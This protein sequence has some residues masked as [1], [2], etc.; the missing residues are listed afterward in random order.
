MN[1]SQHSRCPPF[2]SYKTVYIWC[3]Q[4]MII[5]WFELK[6]GI[7]CPNITKKCNRILA[8]SSMISKKSSAPLLNSF[9]CNT[10]V[11]LIYIN[12]LDIIVYRQVISEMK[13]KKWWGV[14]NVKLS[15]QCSSFIRLWRQCTAYTW[16]AWLG[17]I[18]ERLCSSFW[19]NVWDLVSFWLGPFQERSKNSNIRADKSHH[20]THVT[21]DVKYCAR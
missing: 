2:I 16:S 1:R 19:N 10:W 7:L 4:S 17:E 18:N 14:N 12:D 15:S 6:R 11:Y 20:V 21:L 5:H 13:M 3:Q 9:R 8:F